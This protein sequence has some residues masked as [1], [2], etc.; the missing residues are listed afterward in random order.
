MT[1][2]KDYYQT[3]G[4]DKKAGS[5]EIREAYR[6]LAFQFH[7]DRN[8]ENPAAVE[9]MK[10]INEAYA[11]LSDRKKKDDY[12]TVWERYGTYGYDRFKETY[13]DQDIFRGS[14]IN[15]IFEEMSKGFGLRGFDEVFQESYGQGYRTFEF[16]KPGVFAKGFVFFGPGIGRKNRT[17]TSIPSGAFPGVLEPL[18]RLFLKKGLGLQTSEK[19]RDMLDGISLSPRDILGGRKIRYF[20]RKRSRELEITLPRN[21]KEGQRIRL[22]G[23]GAA[24][25]GG[26]DPGDLYLEVRIRVPL[27][28]RI[29]K[30]FGK[31][32]NR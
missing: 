8:R 17:A 23:M 26:A 28:E 6:K 16:R 18:F 31:W 14:D 15:Q 12:D 20:H 27:L 2:G 25:R 10:E 21:L 29:A 13:S 5:R 30:L 1:N 32:V 24:G 19:G 4:V 11:V 7:P 3:L 22:K 9:R